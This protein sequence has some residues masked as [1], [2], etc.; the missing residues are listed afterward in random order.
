[1]CI[2]PAPLPNRLSASRYASSVQP[3]CLGSWP[4]VITLC[5]ITVSEAMY[6]R[7]AFLKLVPASRSE[8]K[9]GMSNW[10]AYCGII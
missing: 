2:A 8:R 1:M 7:Y 6:P 10:F 4:D 5:A 3:M 9:F